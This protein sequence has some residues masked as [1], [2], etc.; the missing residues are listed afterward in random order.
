MIDIS[1]CDDTFMIR[2]RCLAGPWR[3]KIAYSCSNLVFYNE[4]ASLPYC[5]RCLEE[6]R[7]IT[8]VDVENAM[9]AHMKSFPREK[10]ITYD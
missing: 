8:R 5:D 3:H 1:E 6:F 2:Y 10:E 9:R 7:E 4:G